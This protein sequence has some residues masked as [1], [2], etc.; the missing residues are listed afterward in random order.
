[1]PEKLTPAQ[2]AALIEAARHGHVFRS[3]PR[4]RYTP[5]GYLCHD[6]RV[7]DNLV[8]QGLLEVDHPLYLITDRGREV[9]EGLK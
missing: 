6:H 7:V 3:V 5:Q 8:S 2:K 1:M 4:S 9:A